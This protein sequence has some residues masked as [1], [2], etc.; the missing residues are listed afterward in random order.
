MAEGNP[1]IAAENY[2]SLPASFGATVSNT[3]E[4]LQINESFNANGNYLCGA[5]YDQ[6]D[7]YDQEADYCGGGSPDIV[8]ALGV[9]LTSFGDVVNAIMW[10]KLELTFEAGIQAKV[11]LD[12]HQ[13]DTNPHLAGT[14]RTADVSGVIPA[15]SGLGVPIL[16][17][18]AGDVSP[19]TATVSCDANHIDKI[20]ADGAHFVA[21][22]MRCRIDLSVDYEGLVTGATAGDWLE[23]IIAQSNPNDDTPTSTVTAHQYIDLD[24]P[25]P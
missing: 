16:I 22:N 18:V 10:P 4:T 3:A 11:K 20:G 13:H 1:A 14:I 8:T 2:A 19:V 15:A 21:Q 25:T 24:V 9:H 6:G 5:E 12:G 23:V 17:T 7:I